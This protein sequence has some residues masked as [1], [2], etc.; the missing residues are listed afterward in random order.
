MQSFF[1]LP[2]KLLICILLWI[3]NE[4]CYVCLSGLPFFRRQR[5]FGFDFFNVSCSYGSLIQFFCILLSG[6]N[7]SKVQQ[8]IVCRSKERYEPRHEKTSILHMQK[9][10][11]RSASQ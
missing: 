3:I 9:Q 1:V 8:E 11:H 2:V 5:F 6:Q 10:K 4:K 7:Y